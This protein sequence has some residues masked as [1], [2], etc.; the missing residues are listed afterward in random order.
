VE[1]TSLDAEL[2]RLG[3]DHVDLLKADVEGAEIE[4]LKGAKRLLDGGEVRSSIASYHVVDGKMSCY[5]VEDLLR[6]HGYEAETNFP[7]HPTTYGWRA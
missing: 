6:S 1:V 3:L 7:H 4:M 2:E 5:A